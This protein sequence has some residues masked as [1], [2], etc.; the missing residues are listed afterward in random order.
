MILISPMRPVLPL[1]FRND[2]Q[3]EEVRLRAK[4]AGISVNEFVLRK[5]EEAG[6][7]S[8]S[9]MHVRGDSECGKGDPKA[10]RDRIGKA[11]SESPLPGRPPEQSGAVGGSV[12]ANGGGKRKGEAPAKG[13]GTC[14]WCEGS[15]IEWGPFKRCTKCQRNF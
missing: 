5:Y 11:V 3:Y 15:L 4:E 7:G 12:Q 9:G 1:R 2:E 8:N 14:P 13:L 10:G 6:N